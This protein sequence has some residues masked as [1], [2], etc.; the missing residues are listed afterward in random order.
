[1]IGGDGINDESNK[2]A[3][4]LLVYSDFLLPLVYAAFFEEF[5]VGLVIAGIALNVLYWLAAETLHLCTG[6]VSPSLRFHFRLL[7][8]P[9]NDDRLR[10]V[11]VI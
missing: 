2:T 4:P 9:V 11:P 10:D 6:E 5:C 8:T 3:P 1:M 7:E